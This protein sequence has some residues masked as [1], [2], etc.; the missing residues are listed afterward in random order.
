ME[1]E[2]NEKWEDAGALYGEL[3]DVDLMAKGLGMRGIDHSEDWDEGGD[4]E[5]GGEET[6]RR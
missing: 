1:E 3:R 2:G 5:V 6:E 4:E